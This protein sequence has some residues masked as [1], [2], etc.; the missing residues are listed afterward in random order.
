ML[1]CLLFFTDLQTTKIDDNFFT[2]EI[3]A[4]IVSLFVVISVVGV[5]SVLILRH[6]IQRRIIQDIQP[7]KN[8]N[9][10]I[11]STHLEKNGNFKIPNGMLE[12]KQNI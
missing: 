6:R 3:I 9:S 7:E 5:T 1:E 11:L 10:K 2:P 8:N 4:L 12:K